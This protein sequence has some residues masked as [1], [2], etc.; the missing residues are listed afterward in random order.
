LSVV[1]ARHVKRNSLFIDGELIPDTVFRVWRNREKIELE[2]ADLFESLAEDLCELRGDS[3]NIA[4]L[5]KAAA[6]DERRHAVLCRNILDCEV[7]PRSPLKPALGVPV[8]PQDL[9][10]KGILLSIFPMSLS[11]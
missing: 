7:S 4:S 11:A 8:G 9:D 5:A 10:L 6:Q 2:A 3:D 1:G